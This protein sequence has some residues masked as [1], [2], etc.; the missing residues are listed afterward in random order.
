MKDIESVRSAIKA[1]AS[2]LFSTVGYE[3]TTLEDIASRAGK[4]KTSIYYHYEGKKAILEAVI[5]EEFSKVRN[6]LQSIK[7]GERERIV[8]QLTIY[9][10]KR[11][12]LLTASKVYKKY[13]FSPYSSP[14][15]EIAQIVKT[16]RDDFDKWEE[17]YFFGVCKAGLEVGALSESVNPKAFSEMLIMVLKGLEVQF[18]TTNDIET[19]KATYSG[20][21]E[22]LLAGMC[23]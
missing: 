16:H 22:R 1:S 17:S 4:A 12:E 2:E 7:D 6:A 20:V 18:F 19:I 21:L 8:S 3:K 14:S 9:L 5:D 11:M 15:S 23:N 10:E 13:F